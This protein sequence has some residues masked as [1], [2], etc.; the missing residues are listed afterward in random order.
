MPSNLFKKPKELFSTVEVGGEERAT[1]AYR[2]RR[3]GTRDAANER[4]QSKTTPVIDVA[5]CSGCGRCVAACP[6]RIITL[7]T[8]SYRKHAVLTELK[9][10]TG[11]A[12]CRD[13]CPLGAIAMAPFSP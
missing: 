5:R 9:R 11:C 13:A 1:Q 7:E 4:L 3:R 2:T 8:A 10:C 6:Q 12:A